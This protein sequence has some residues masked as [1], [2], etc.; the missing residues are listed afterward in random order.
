MGDF[1]REVVRS[2]PERMFSFQNLQVPGGYV[3]CVLNVK[4][5]KCGDNLK[6]VDYTFVSAEDFLGK[7]PTWITIRQIAKAAIKDIEAN[8]KPSSFSDDLPNIYEEAF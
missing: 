7:V 4:L 2:A 6:I 1:D 8:Y 3:N 5:A